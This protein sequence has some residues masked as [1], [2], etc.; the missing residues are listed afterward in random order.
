MALGGWPGAIIGGLN[1]G[2]SI[3]NAVYRH[4]KR[5]EERNDR[6]E[7]GTKNFIIQ[8]ESMSSKHKSAEEAD[9]LTL[10]NLA[11]NNRYPEFNNSLVFEELNKLINRTNLYLTRYSPEGDILEMIKD[12]YDEYGYDIYLTKQT[13]TGIND[14]KKHIQ[15]LTIAKNIHHNNTIRQMI[16]LRLLNGVKVI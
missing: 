11:N 3:Y 9:R 12:H 13:C 5:T 2:S 4:T 16:E 14:I 15:F 1:I 10:Q 6:L 7:F 8:G